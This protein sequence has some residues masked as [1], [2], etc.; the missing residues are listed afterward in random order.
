MNKKVFFINLLLFILMFSLTSLA[1]NYSENITRHYANIKIKLNNQEIIAK[2]ENGTIIEPFIING[3]TYLPVRAIGNALN[4]DVSFDSTTNT[5][6]LNSKDEVQSLVSADNTEIVVV[7]IVNQKD[8]LPMRNSKTLRVGD[9]LKLSAIYFPKNINDDVALSWKSSN[10]KVAKINSSGVVTCL[11]EG[12][13]TITVT[14]DNDVSDSLKLKV[15]ENENQDD[16]TVATST[17]A[18]S[19]IKNNSSKSNNATLDELYKKYNIAPPTTNT[20]ENTNVEYYKKYVTSLIKEQMNSRGLLDSSM[21]TQSINQAL[22]DVNSNVIVYITDYGKKYHT[23][24]CQYLYNS[25]YSIRKC[26]AI[27]QGYLPCSICSP[28]QY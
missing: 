1:S 18:T 27:E 2:D 25:I 11:S 13:T 9:T 23:Y 14:T 24:S 5:V 6:L 16:N 26:N 22:E 17:N 19:T 10:S 8:N 20:V 4:L 3:T 15:K 7:D 21:T 12:T 28:W